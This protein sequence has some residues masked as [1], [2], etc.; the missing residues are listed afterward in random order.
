MVLAGYVVTRKASTAFSPLVMREVGKSLRYAIA[1][2]VRRC[3]CDVRRIQIAAHRSIGSAVGCRKI[4]NSGLPG[5][6]D[7]LRVR[8]ARFDNMLNVESKFTRQ[9]IVSCFKLS[10][11]ATMFLYI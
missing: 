6:D 1:V 3:A 5:G 9:I 8:Y 2:A 7:K 10:S 4:A 11:S